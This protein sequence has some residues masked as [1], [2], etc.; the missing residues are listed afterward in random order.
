MKKG[1]EIGGS[2]WKTKDTFTRRDREK[3]GKHIAI[4]HTLYPA[5]AFWELP[6]LFGE[7]RVK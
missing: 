7:L 6:G 1:E 4:Q 5:L 3:S 2:G